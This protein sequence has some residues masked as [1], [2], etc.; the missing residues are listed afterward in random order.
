MVVNSEMT[1]GD[2]VAVNGYLWMLTEPLRMAGWWV[3]DIQ[4]FIT[5]VENICYIQYRA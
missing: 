1:M 2:F 3:N 5:S 4:R